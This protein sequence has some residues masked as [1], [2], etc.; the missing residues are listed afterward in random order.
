MSFYG[1]KSKA[2]LQRLY[3]MIVGIQKVFAEDNLPMF[4][5]DNLIA[6]GR[7]LSFAHEGKFKT[8]FDR[9]AVGSEDKSKIWRIHTYCWAAHSALSVP[10]DFVECGVFLGLYSATLLDY[11]DWDAADKQIY[12]YDT[13]EGLAEKYATDREL[14]DLGDSYEI[15]DWHRRVIERF[16]PYSRVEIVKGVVP[17]VL[18]ETSPQ[19]ISLLHLDMNAASAETGAL[20]V[21]FERVSDGGFVL[22]DDYGRN[23]NHELHLALR[24]WMKDHGHNILELPTGQGL[25]VK[26]GE[27]AAKG[28]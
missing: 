9:N 20:D 8:A 24:D 16:S 27:G 19:H 15:E 17:D 23:E 26:R 25:V 10:G 18:A 11:L 12:L 14:D 6:L 21:L 3:D 5:G 13:F 1:P 7:N 28:S 4:S 2:G 22:M